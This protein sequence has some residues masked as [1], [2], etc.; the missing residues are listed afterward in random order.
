VERAKRQ[1]RVQT[2]ARQVVRCAGRAAAQGSHAYTSD[3]HVYCSS[4][5]VAALE[6]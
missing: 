6:G 4:L 2:T 5:S 3:T 1:Q